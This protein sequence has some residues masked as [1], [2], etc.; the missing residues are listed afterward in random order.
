MVRGYD[1]L[2][3]F[4]DLEVTGATVSFPVVFLEKTINYGKA[5]F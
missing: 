3:V 1:S 2:G 4:R 5:F